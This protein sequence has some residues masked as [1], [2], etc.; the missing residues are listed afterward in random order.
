MTSAEFV[1]ELSSLTVRITLGAQ[2]EPPGS[3]IFDQQT[4]RDHL[5]L[6]DCRVFDI[7]HRL[8]AACF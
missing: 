2:L 1:L 7:S 3:L 5:N 8:K 4:S 6:E